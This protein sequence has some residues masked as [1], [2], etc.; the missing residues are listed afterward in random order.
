MTEHFFGD[1]AVLLGRS[2]RHITRSMDTIITTTVVPVALLLL[3]VYVFGGAIKTGSDSYVN[4]L[5]P[6]ILL[7]TIASGIAYTAVRLFVDMNSGIFERFQSMPIARSSVLWAHV[8]TSVVANLISLAAVVAVAFLIGFR[9]E[10]GL[11]GWLAVAGILILFTVALTWLAV[12]PGLSAKSADGASA[13][14]Y[15]LIFLPFISAAFVPT[16]TM[17]GPVRAFAEHQPVT[18]IVNT[19]RDLFTQQAVGTDIWIALSWCVGILVVACMLA[20]ATY[21]RISS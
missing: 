12:I 8:L 20:M 4:Y 7:I 5:L 10:A 13:F 14:S 15:P 16:D 9:S 17:P 19:M 3:F 21:R 2:L 1:T 11:L 18:S 6:G